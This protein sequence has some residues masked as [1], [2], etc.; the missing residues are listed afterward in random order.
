[1]AESSARTPPAATAAVHHVHEVVRRS[2]TSFLWGMRVLPPP[3]REAMFAIYAFCREVDDVADEPGEPGA[4]LARLE[5]W[6]AEIARLYEG[7]PTRPTTR[8][9]AGPVAAYGLPRDEFLAVI[10]GMEMD[11]REAMVAPSLE[12]FG[13]YC[14]RVAGAVGMLS[15]HAFGAQEPH[16]REIAVALGEAL[17]I[18]N[19]LRDLAEDAARGRLYLPREL[20]EAHGIATR[21]PQAV[22]DHP[23]LAPASAELAARARARF[24]RTRELIGSCDPRPIKPCILMMQIYERVLARLEARG[25]HRPREAV[26]V[27]KVEKLW[28]ALRYGLL[29]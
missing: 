20:L 15:I 9:L 21:D 7:R 3:R 18:T 11:A 26:R 25:W 4:K 10:D 6:R 22:L 5:E 24:Q 13:L 29:G 27:S 19:I 28:I 8:A 12:D 2:G 16:A 23:G 17:Q 14:R 1:M